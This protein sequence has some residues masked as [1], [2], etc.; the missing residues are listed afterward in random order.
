MSSIFSMSRILAGFEGDGSLSPLFPAQR[1]KHCEIETGLSPV[2]DILQK[3][4]SILHPPGQR[5]DA[6][7][8]QHALHLR[9]DPLVMMVERAGMVLRTGVE[10][11]N[12]ACHD[13]GAVD[14]LDNPGE[15]N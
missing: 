9:P 10:A 15:R 4:F 1:Y 8:F 5:L 6:L 12:A 13:A 3:T 2:I 7:V 11:E 14:R